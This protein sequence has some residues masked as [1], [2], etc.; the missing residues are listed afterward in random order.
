MSEIKAETTQ[1]LAQQLR[2]KAFRAMP[3]D[4][5]FILSSDAANKAYLSGYAA[6]A[7]DITPFYRSA[8]LSS[9]DRAALVVSAADAGGAYEALG[10]ASLLFRYGEFFFE[11]GDDGPAEFRKP[12]AASFEAALR[13]MIVAFGPDS[14]QVGIDRAND[15]LVWDLARELLGESRVVDVTQALAAARATKT[16][17]EVLRLRHATALVE[18]GFRRIIA[19]ARPGMTEIEFAA[20][21]SR[22][23]VEGGGVPRFVSVSSGTRSALAD[24]Y[25]TRRPIAKG[26][27]VRID[28]GCTVDGYWSDMARTF[29]FGQVDARQRRT[30]D[31][32]LAGLEAELAAVREGMAA[33]ALFEITMSA[34]RANGLPHYRR[35]HCGHGIGLRS[36]D[37]PTIG[38]RDQTLLRAGMCLCL[39]TPYYALGLDGMMVEDTICVTTTGHEPITTLSRELFVL[40]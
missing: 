10:D 39:E 14:S 20:M 15:D 29:V 23:M 9:R 4:V 6:M 11:T 21:I 25:P 38:S 24:V 16:A 5:G 28:A 30:Y 33:S 17:G 37:S 26:E 12:T 1:Q 8:V 36:Y 2:D 18:E 19:D 27:A 3:D 34:V 22:A 35:Q 32:L 31:A 40:D 7:H 13:D